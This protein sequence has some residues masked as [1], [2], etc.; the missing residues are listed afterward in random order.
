MNNGLILKKIEKNIDNCI[1]NEKVS[2]NI[3]QLIGYVID[4]INRNRT[5]E[6]VI[7]ELETILLKL[8]QNGFNLTVKTF[9]Y[10]IISNFYQEFNEQFLISMSP[11]ISSGLTNMENFE[12]NINSFRNFIILNQKEIIDNIPNIENILKGK[13]CDI[14]YIINCF[15]FS[16]FPILLLN[17]IKKIPDE[18]VRQYKDFLTKLFLELAK[19]LFCKLQDVTFLNLTQLLGKL[20]SNFESCTNNNE[21]F[22]KIKLI[23]STLIPMAEYLI[24]HLE[25]IV[26]L[27]K[28]FDNKLLSQSISFPINLFKIYIYYKDENNYNN[29]NKYEKHF[30]N[31]MKFIFQEIRN[32]L[33]PDIFSEITKILCEYHILIKKDKNH[34]SNFST[35]IIEILSKFITFIEHLDKSMWFDNNIKN[36]SYLINYIDYNETIQYALILLKETYH[37]KNY[38]DRIITLYNLFNCIVFLSINYSE[39]FENESVILCL[40][41][42][43][44][45]VVLVNKSEI[46]EKESRW[47]S[48][49]FICLIESIFNIKKYIL[50][51]KKLDNYINIIKLCQD[52]V[53]V[54]YKILDWKDEGES[55][56]MY[57]LILEK[58]CL[59]FGEPFYNYLYG[60]LPDYSNMKNRLDDVLNEIAKR[61]YS[62][63]WES[64]LF[65]NENSKYY[66]LLILCKYL[67]PDQT[68]DINNLLEI[69]TIHLKEMNFEIQKQNQIEKLLL[70]LLF[71][72]IR[73]EKVLKEKIIKTIEDYDEYLKNK[74][75]AGDVQ[76]IGNILSLAENIL[77][78]LVEHKNDLPIVLDNKKV[79]FL[80]NEFYLIVS[81]DIDINSETKSINYNTLYLMNLT[82][83]SFSVLDNCKEYNSSV[84]LDYFKKFY[85]YPILE[86]NKDNCHILIDNNIKYISSEWELITGIADA[87]HIYYRYIIDI[88]TREIEIFL[89]NYNTTNVVLNNVIIFVYL[90]ENLIEIDSNKNI[91]DLIN[92]NSNIIFQTSPEHRIELLSPNSSFD[93]SIKCY[94]KKFDLNF[95]SVEAQFDMVTDQKGQ[96][97]LRSEPFYI[98]LTDFFIPDKYSLFESEKYEIFYSTLEYGFSTKCFSNCSADEIINDISN[99]L[100]LIEYKS[101][102]IT[103]K[104]QNEIMEDIQK[105]KYKEYYEKLNNI[106]DDNKANKKSEENNKNKHRENFKIKLSTYCVYNFWLYIFIIGD[107]NSMYNKAIL[108]IDFKTNDLK[109][110]NIIAK[111]KQFF[112]NELISSKIKFY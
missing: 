102:N 17:I 62:K 108:N 76:L 39:Y 44:W 22:E 47:R 103:Y 7:N 109:G 70:C 91:S 82:E 51:K 98:P 37:I 5:N 86:Y 107:Y 12:R 88:D 69:I 29:Y 3:E 13:T 72:G 23:N 6:S 100:T 40:F 55:F 46:D 65:A 11:L 94:S 45:F 56:K 96:F 95:I 21:D 18:E 38:S 111:E 52:I 101:N 73:V 63:K 26:F 67:K 15:Y 90:N 60:K 83:N 66:S 81:K 71:L 59:F 20:L 97:N 10:Y 54:C 106:D 2:F 4:K 79:D 92:K 42:Q 80:T 49:I 104:K 34:I 14:N 31:Y 75:N 112:I 33:E 68:K 84:Y 43:E 1:K 19:L 32:I 99:K 36:L 24:I 27:M 53:D 89:K 93:F 85:Y 48:D 78:H 110:L 9:C 8:L 61:F 50:K 77:Y 58:T 41:K 16:N 28:S 64:L 74:L 57:F 30:H 25:E 105:N 87:I 35:E